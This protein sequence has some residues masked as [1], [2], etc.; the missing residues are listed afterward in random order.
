[1][2]KLLL[3]ISILLCFCS[4][5]FAVYCS[6]CGVENPDNAKYCSHCG[7][8]LVNKAS[9]TSDNTLPVLKG[10]VYVVLGSGESQIQRGI[11]I[12]LIK[13]TDEF[14]NKVQ[15][16]LKG[17]ENVQSV[18]NGVIS[19]CERLMSQ[20]SFINSQQLGQHLGSL[21]SAE[22]FVEYSIEAN[23][24]FYSNSAKT[25]TTT[26]INGSFVFN[27]T[28]VGQFYLF[29][30]Y[31]TSFDD[32]YW[33]VPVSIKNN[34]GVT[35]ELNSNNISSEKSLFQYKKLKS[36]EEGFLD[37][38]RIN[39]GELTRDR[40]RVYQLEQMEKFKKSYY[41]DTPYPQPISN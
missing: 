26:D 30:R 6:L 14:Q 5:A 13:A 25:S 1:M 20:G 21:S 34:E 31:H 27:E 28:S 16:I 12:Y 4:N 29:A 38:I 17:Q 33:L 8:L 15:T 3:I 11:K 7:K 10:T 23:D 40:T 36:L 24:F 18:I 9:N 37:L 22:A 41:Q 32:D 35:V 2:K 19:E 39:E